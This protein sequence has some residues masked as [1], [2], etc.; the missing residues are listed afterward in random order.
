MWLVVREVLALDSLLIDELGK[1]ALG[2]VGPQCEPQAVHDGIHGN[3]LAP[4]HCQWGYLQPIH[5]HVYTYCH[6]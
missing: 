1:G 5:V 4:S 2:M 3:H 6:Q